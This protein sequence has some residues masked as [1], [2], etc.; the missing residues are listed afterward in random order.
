QVLSFDWL[1]GAGASTAPAAGEPFPFVDTRDQ[2]RALWAL[3]DALRVE[4][5]HAVVGC[6]YG[7]MVA[8]HVAALAPERCRRL[9][10]I[11]AAHRSDPQASAWRLVQRRIVELSLR[12]G[13]DPQ[14]R[15]QHLALARGLAMTTYRSPHELRERFSGGLDDD[16]LSGWLDARGAR[17]AAAWNAEQFLCCNRSIDAHRID[18]AEVTAAAFVCA[19]DSDQLVPARDVLEFAL[20][21]PDLRG[22]RELRT[23]YGHDGFL[24]ETAAVSAF[25]REALR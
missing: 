13:L 3:C 9:V 6:S 12:R 5:L 15:A 22:H 4:R 25:V 11:A 2:A 17:F 16:A 20:G 7:G 18:P 24:K 8:Q 21:L 10:S 1:G 14:A 19:F 23:A